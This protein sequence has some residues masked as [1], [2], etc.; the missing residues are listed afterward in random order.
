[1]NSS[2]TSLDTAL[3][4]AGRAPAQPAGSPDARA[5]FASIL[6]RAGARDAPPA[7][8]A[9]ESA[10]QLVSIALVQ[11]I[12]AQARSANHAPPP[13]APNQAQRTF[14]A[15]LDA[16]ISH[17]IVKSQH[18]GLV[19]AVARRV[20]KQGTDAAEPRDSESTKGGIAP[21]GHAR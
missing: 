2:L 11:P 8:K 15:M 1:M 12:L 10:E 5:D 9:R 16:Q 17:S 19:D 13:F 20:L 6:A 21:P 7:Q 14:G 18:W 4:P 3:T